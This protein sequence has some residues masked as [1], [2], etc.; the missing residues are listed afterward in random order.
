MRT[1]LSLK[2]LVIF[3]GLLSG[4]SAWGQA[5]KGFKLLEAGDPVGA[6]QAFQQVAPDDR[7]Y[8]HVLFGQGQVLSREVFPRHNLDSAYHYFVLAEKNYRSLSYKDRQKLEPFT[9]SDIRQWQKEIQNRVVAATLESSD[10]A[11]ADA[12]LARYDKLPSKDKRALME[13]RNEWL[14]TAVTDTGLADFFRQYHQDF[15][16]YSPSLL[17]QMENRLFEVAVGAEQWDRYPDFA[18]RFPQ[19]SYVRQG[20]MEKTL[21]LREG[22]D[23]KAYFGFLDAYG[24][25]PFRTLVL[26]S[27]AAAV[28]YRGNLA[29][30]ERYVREFAGEHESQAVWEHYYNLYKRYDF[31]EA[32]IRAFDEK[33]PDFPFPEQ[34]ERDLNFFV[35][36]KFEAL[37][38]S[39]FTMDGARDFLQTYPGF[40][41]IE[42]L[43]ERYYKVY[44]LGNPMPE[45]LERFLRENPAY[46]FPDSV[47]AERLVM[48]DRRAEAILSNESVSI[49]GYL[50]F[51]DK[52]PET[53]RRDAIWKKIYQ[54]TVAD[55]PGITTLERFAKTYPNYP[56]MD[57]LQTEKRRQIEQMSAQLLEK[58]D[59]SAAALRDFI[60]QYPES[61]QVTALW[62]RIYGISL[63][64]EPTATDLRT[65]LQAYPDYPFAEEVQQLIRRI[66]QR[67]EKKR[68]D[69]IVD[70]RRAM[71]FLEDYPGSP[72][73][74]ALEDRIYQML[75]GSYRLQNLLKF[76]EIYPESRYR[77]EILGQVYVAMT[78]DG[79][80]S[81]VAAFE[82]RYPDFEDKKQLERDRQLAL[83]PN[84]I[85]VPYT[86]DK[87][88]DFETYIRQAAPGYRAY[89]VLYQYIY[90][91]LQAENWSAAAR[92]VRFFKADFGDAYPAYNQ[93]LTIFD[94]S[95]QYNMQRKPIS[96]MVNTPAEEYAPVISADGQTLLFCGRFRADNLGK[97]DIFI[98]HRSGGEWQA[99]QLLRDLSSAADNEAPEAISADNN[100]MLLFVDGELGISE[101]TADGWS[102]VEKLPS[103]INRS[104]WQA[105]ARI[106][107]DG[108]AMLF[109][110]EEGD[111]GKRD[112]Y[113]SVKD[114]E[115]N[116]GEAI[117]LGPVINTT[118]V[119]RTPFLHPDMKTLYFSSVGHTGLGKMD[120]FMSK[121]LDE[122]SW[123]EWSEPVNLGTALNSV[124]NDWDFKV[125]TDGRYAYFTISNDIF[126]AELPSVFQPERVAT[127]SGRLVGIDGKPLAAEI[128]WQDLETGEVVQISK[129][130]PQT[131]DFFAT[132]P[133]KGIFGYTVQREGFFPLSG[134]VDFTESVSDIKLEQDMILATV[135]QMQEQDIRLPLNNLFFETAKY[136]IKPRS[137]PELN[138]LA[139]WIGRYDLEIEIMGHTDDVGEEADNRLLSQNRADAVKEYLVGRGAPV[140]RIMAT[141]FG[142]DQ[143]I[144]T[145]NTTEGRAQNRRVEIRIRR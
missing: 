82:Q 8:A 4:V 7:T 31:S 64:D 136:D 3:W 46:L 115:G 140:D 54:L 120:V 109:A 15:A 73:L 68:F 102:P 125:T 135:E 24:Q 107:A 142:E 63:Q 101:K 30:C 78:G 10:P 117:N 85:N 36:R 37:M 112:I 59:A 141:G 6:W 45:D 38:A 1:D 47:S 134:N 93:L 126:L 16:E 77:Q 80:L 58:P 13:A 76:L 17:R 70:L 75:A 29:D 61:D 74:P 69:Q 26:D 145:N 55:N 137:F 71:E 12:V 19:H 144:A 49:Q 103:T 51:L 116:W 34:L 87:Q 20:L 79:S 131:G 98:A 88:A 41:G 27:L 138:R 90:P 11:R 106:T 9:L 22:R 92:K 129:S 113:V 139:E 53:S 57:E 123:T 40:P 28:A 50:I 89:R 86:P 25:T 43:W 83:L 91:D 33:Y 84:L 32:S 114:E 127:V 100:T 2:S 105:D 110:S 62:R 119:D 143:P 44:K 39:G 35:E 65:F 18:R 104:Y 132:L 14:W 56:F 95:D 118:E 96:D 121:R 97:E 133:K 99:P 72:Y 108:K 128:L 48:I 111:Y 67:D 42:A 21:A 81:S 94:Q 52:Y 122:N 60:Q 23:P 66:N 124:G 5:D 130:D